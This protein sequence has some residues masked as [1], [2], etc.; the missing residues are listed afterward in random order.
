M[1]RYA[2]VR[3]ADQ[4]DAAAIVPLEVDPLGH[5]P[6]RD[7]EE[8]CAAATVARAAVVIQRE[9]GLHDIFR[10]DEDELVLQNTG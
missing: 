3:D 6:P 7:G 2:L 9:G 1:Y 4:D 5:F 10:F 8:E